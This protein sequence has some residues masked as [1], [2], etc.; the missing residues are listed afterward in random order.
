MIAAVGGLSSEVEHDFFE[1]P[2]A[3]PGGGPRGL[4]RSELF[5]IDEI[6]SDRRLSLSAARSE[7]ADWWC[8]KHIVS[9]ADSDADAGGV[10]M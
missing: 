8:K 2:A 7:I 9:R 6:F 3:Q 4:F 5:E 1:L 10:P